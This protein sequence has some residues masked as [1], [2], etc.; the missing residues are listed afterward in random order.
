M[1][2][3]K[4]L[5]ADT[6]DVAGGE[7]EVAFYLYEKLPRD[8][9]EVYITGEEGSEY[10]E[11]K[12]PSDAEWLRFGVKGKTNFNRM[13]AFRKLVKEMQ[14]DIVHVHGY[15]AG[16]FVRMACMGKRDF[17]LVWTMHSCVDDMFGGKGLKHFIS[18]AIENILNRNR[19]F[20][21][22][23]V[24]VNENSKKK[25]IGRKVKR[26]PVHTIY[27]GIEPKLFVAQNVEE[28]QEGKE[29]CLGF[30]SR[31]NEQKG[32]YVFLDAVAKLRQKS[33][34]LR[35]IIAGNGEAEEEIKRTIER[36]RL[37]DCVHMIGFRKDI[38]NVLKQ[39]D[40]LILPSF[41]ECF[42]MVILESMCMKKPVIATNINGIPE[43]ITDGE[44]GY[45]VNVGSADD[46]VSC[47]MEYWKEP[48]KLLWQGENAYQTV[49]S[50][51]TVD[52]MV[53]GYVTLFH[54]ISKKE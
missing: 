50:K 14:F 46:I 37:S 13:L 43:Q 34:L 33:V 3:I 7:Q 18:T 4:V 25:L 9:F 8:Q 30:I 39:I 10:F 42:P 28:K 27:N 24:T 6:F 2:K 35:V 16:F 11:K 12:R 1:E 19:F 41:S 47:V 51:F 31:L 15:S 38:A 17:K 20:T 54:T 21:D 45:L 29:I 48:D 5:I 53:E 44:N 32:I 52:K 40:V 26:V 23:I 36:L 49:T 22:H